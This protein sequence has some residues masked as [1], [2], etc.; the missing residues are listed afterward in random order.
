MRYV[1]VQGKVCAMKG[2]RAFAVPKATQW[3]DQIAART[4]LRGNWNRIESQ[5]STAR[6][7]S[8]QRR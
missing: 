3:V 6:L 1:I 4:E 7:I 5:R 8:N 2:G